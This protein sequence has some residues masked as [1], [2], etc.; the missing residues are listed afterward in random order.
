MSRGNRPAPQRGPAGT[1]H[2]PAAGAEVV[3]IVPQEHDEVLAIA[4][5][6]EL[7]DGLPREVF[8]RSVGELGDRVR[9]TDL[10]ALRLMAWALHRSSEAQRDVE[11]NGMFEV[12]EIYGKRPNPALK[13]ARDEAKL[14]LYIAD[15][16][17]LT[18]VSRL[19]AGIL[20]LAGQSMMEQLHESMAAAI[21]SR[22]LTHDPLERRALEAAIELHACDECGRTFGSHRGLAVHRH[23]AHPPKKKRPQAKRPRKRKP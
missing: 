10:E 23:R 4:I 11:D 18:F 7:P 17:A 15:Q 2:H 8:I 12:H 20:Q 16:Y 6:E 19:R 13:V 3:E 22:I 1:S 9:D 21:V 14:Y 5:A